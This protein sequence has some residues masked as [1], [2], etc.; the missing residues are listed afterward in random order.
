MNLRHFKKRARERG[1]ALI[2]VMSLA[3]TALLM[4]ASVMSWANEN[5]T[6][7]ARNNEYFATTYAAEAATE[8]ALG[9]MVQDDQD[10][11][12][13]TVFTQ[14]AYYSTLIPTAQDNYYWTNYQ[15]SGGTVNNSVL[16]SQV[17]ASTTNV[18]GPP[19]AGLICVGATYD[20]IANAKKVNSPYG[21]VS[22][23]G[24]KI[25]L[26]QIP[27]FQFAIFYQDTMEIDP[28]ANMTVTGLVHGNTNIFLDPNSGVTLQFNGDVSASGVINLSENP[29]DPTSRPGG[30]TINFDGAG[31]NHIGNVNPMNLPVGTNTSGTSTNIDQ[32]VL[33]ILQVPPAGEVPG[34]PVGTN[35]LYNQVDMI[36]TI[37]NGNNITVTSGVDIDGRATIISNNQW[38]GFITTNGSFY[39]GREGQTVDPVNI[40]VSNLMQW[41]ENSTNSL[42]SALSSLR[43]SSFEYVSSIYVVDQ[44]TLSNSVVITN[45]SYTTNTATLTTT[46]YPAAGAYLPPV[47]TNTLAT[48]S[49]SYPAANTFFP[50]VTTNTTST[51]SSTYP[52]TGTYVPPVTTNTT[53]TS[54]SS[55]PTAG[56]Y[57]G[58][59]TYSSGKYHYNLITGYT[60]NSIT[61]YI[62]TGI[63]GYTYTGITG[64]TTNIS[65]TTNWTQFAI[66]GIVLTNGAVLPPNGLSIATPDPA[67]IVGNWNVSTNTSTP[68]SLATSNTVNTL[69]SAVYADAI[70]VLSPAWN[71][72]N[73]V[74]ANYNAAST[75][76]VNAAF[77]TGNVP[78]N[79]IYYSGGVENF[80]RF[81]ENWTGQNFY[82]NGSMV[83]M[84]P[85]QIA[86]APWPGTGVVYS[87]PT[88]NW[89]F[90]MNFNNPSELPPLTPKAI[91]LLRA[92]W[93]TL[94][95]GTTAANF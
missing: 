69:P 68:A 39:D 88:R 18:L 61:G 50:P 28:G 27:L 53:P 78:S 67:Y 1:W 34:G 10:Y 21:I 79:D 11:G 45:I 77:L 25:T 58:S 46:T 38:A 4:L 71:P 44:R 33:S 55:S 52:G 87:P 24:Q 72:A 63:T 91:Y 26:G 65:Y 8:K 16:V 13:G 81:L 42:R 82:Y 84:F 85:S 5:A 89:T 37:S 57:I 90:D 59:V 30:G 14:T 62:Y 80:P 6:V 86:T 51:T 23:V 64:V 3:A 54:S 22:T 56:T 73:N 60:Y 41:T 12:E 66:P 36:I 29:L 40:N 47:A 43:G 70:T 9:A 93:Q 31:S 19:Y 20:I 74:S 76:T 83:E 94:P 48:T 17:S 2:V 7:V 75:D 35:R 49:P 92:Q 95:P 15:F 32:N